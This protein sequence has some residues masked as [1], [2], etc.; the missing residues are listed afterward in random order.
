MIVKSDQEFIRSYL[1]D[2]SNLQ[3]GYAEKVVIPQNIEEI[4]NSL[5]QAH[6]QRVPV[7]IS[8]AGTGQAGARIPFG[9]IVISLEKLNAVKEIKKREKGGYVSAEAGA[10]IQDLKAA[11]RDR[12]LFYTYDPTEQS[13]FLGG[14]IATNASGARSFRYGPT[15]KYVNALTVILADGTVLALRRGD[16]KAKKRIISF[17]AGSKRYD[18]KLPGYTMPMVKHSAGYYIEDDMD[19]LDLFVGQEGTL[20]LIVDS[21][22]ELLDTPPGIFSAFVFF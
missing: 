11:C 21:E 19:L 3:G 13:A 17:E 18:I 7:S 4:K 8:G 6:E 14:T 12:G 22:L 20:G 16:I 15:R 2:A 9:G 1:E 5:K 10:A